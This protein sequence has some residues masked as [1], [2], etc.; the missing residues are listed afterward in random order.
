MPAAGTTIPENRDVNVTLQ[1]L[2]RA[3]R[4]H[5]IRTRTVPKNFEEFVAASQIRFP[6]PPG[7]KKYVIQGQAVVLVDSK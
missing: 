2:T 3:L 1:E 4:E 5:V 6:P 7:G